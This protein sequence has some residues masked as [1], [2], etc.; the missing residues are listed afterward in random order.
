[1]SPLGNPSGQQLG[2]GHTSAPVGIWGPQAQV[3]QVLTL[4]QPMWDQA[5]DPR[6]AP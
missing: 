2:R 6:A 1:M 3:L 4:L 5:A